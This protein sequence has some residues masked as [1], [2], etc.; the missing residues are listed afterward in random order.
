MAALGSAR[1]LA[2]L[3]PE[4]LHLIA[5]AYVDDLHA[6]G[7]SNITSVLSS[8]S[9]L[10]DL[11]LP[12]LYASVHI[13]SLEQLVRFV[14]PASGAHKYCAD[15]TRDALVVNIPGVP[16]GGDGTCTDPMQRRTRATASPS[17]RAHSRCAHR[18]KR[19]RWSFSAFDTARSSP[20]PTFAPPKPPRLQARSPD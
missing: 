6:A 11:V 9:L 12:K 10:H 17:Y 13:Y 2:S 16:G 20:R 3:P 1:Y 8:C 14:A 15:Y 4:I 5:A 18:Y 7:T 19:C